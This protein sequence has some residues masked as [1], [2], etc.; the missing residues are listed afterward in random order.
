MKKIIYFLASAVMISAACTKNNDIQCSAPEQDGTKTFPVSIS[1]SGVC[2][3]TKTSAGDNDVLNDIQVVLYRLNGTEKTYESF[4]SFEP[5]D[6]S[7]TIYIDPSKDADSYLIAAYANQGL[8]ESTRMEDWASFSN[9]AFDDMQMY[10]EWRDS[11][12]KLLTERKADIGLER[13]C[14]KV[15]VRNISLDWSNSANKYKTFT[16]KGYYLA[17]TEGVLHNLYDVTGSFGRFNQGGT[18]GTDKASFLCNEVSDVEITEEEAYNVESSLYAYI[19]D[20]SRLVI[21][22]EFDGEECYY[23][24]PVNQDTN[25]APVSVTGYN[26]QIRNV[27]FDFKKITI[28]KPGAKTPYGALTEENDIQVNLSVTPW[29]NISYDNIEIR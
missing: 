21:E 11:K 3:D 14:S 20:A 7:G 28:T 17:D 23:S 8:T 16:L 29:T 18:K 13:Y 12:D 15:T 24:I 26:G 19:S 4:Y 27:H 2:A 22:A 25:V 6:M 9:E 10:G 1:L 5:D